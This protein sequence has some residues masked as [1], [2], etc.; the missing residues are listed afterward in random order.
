VKTGLLVAALTVVWFLP[1]A[2]AMLVGQVE[3]H[4]RSRANETPLVLGHAGS[5]LE[6]TFNALHF[7]KPD[8]VT[9]PY[10]DA[11]QVNE[12]GKGQ[13]IPL[14]ARYSAGDYRIVGTTFDYF[15]FRDLEFETGRAFLR[16]G[17]C[18]VGADVAVR[19]G[20]EVGDSVVSSP[21]TLF[22]LAGVYP[23]RM[24]VVGVLASTGSPDDSA[25]FVDLK[26]TWIIEGLGH[27]HKEAAEATDEE[28]LD[29]ADGGVVRL[30][31]SVV[32]YNEIT[33]ETMESFHF[34]GELENNPITAAVVIPRGV[35]EQ[36]LLKG[37]FAS[38]P[39]RQLVAPAA[40][41]DEL[42]ATVF[43]VQRA[44]LSF[45]IFVGTA[46]LALGILTFTLSHRLRKREFLSLQM[47]GASP[48]MLRGLVLFEATF[49]LLLSWILSSG[50]LAALFQI[51]PAA[52]SRFF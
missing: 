28:R 29:S 33:P 32:E 14:Y 24:S 19:N 11:I 51:A 6:L 8:I 4:L 9:F 26:T 10:E 45:L 18:V 38:L 44:V 34:H 47:I 20:I 35:K 25:I 48:G 12:E 42:F 7:T 5:A 50:L 3:E 21:E 46:T 43:S 40:E 16:M 36:A 37:Q 49:V 52:I 31:A 1:F 13:A 41:M 27:G 23:L 22:D 15:R 30:N 2:I 39:E 17:E